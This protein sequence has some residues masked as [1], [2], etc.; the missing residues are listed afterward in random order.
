MSADHEPVSLCQAEAEANAAD[1]CA[2]WTF[3]HNCTR[4]ELIH[5]GV[6]QKTLSYRSSRPAYRERCS[7]YAARSPDLAGGFGA[8]I[9]VKAEAR[10]QPHALP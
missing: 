4:I 10:S 7:R 9:F 1:G 3:A 6:L 5:L 8:I 2:A